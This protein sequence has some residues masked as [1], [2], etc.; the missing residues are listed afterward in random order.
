MTNRTD[1]VSP[2]ALVLTHALEKLR[3]RD[4]L[5]SSRLENS[6]SLEAA[7]LL[8]LAAVRRYAAIQN[9]EIAEAALDVI[10]ECLRESIRGSQSIVADAVLGLGTF[11]EAYNR[12][13][14]D[15]RAVSALRSGLLGMRRN[16]LLASWRSLHEALGLAPLEPPSDRAL[17][18]TVEPAVLRELARQLIRREEYSLGSKSVVM[19]DA[20]ENSPRKMPTSRPGRVL[21]VGGAVMDA[22]FRTKVLPQTGTSSEAYAFE[23]APG[24]KGLNQAVAAARLGLDVA[25]VAAVADDRFGHEIVNHLQDERVDTSL[26][27]QVEDA[28]TPFTGVIEFELGDSLALNWPNQREVRLDVRDLDKYAR[29]FAE[30][31]AVLVTFEIPRE[32]VQHV[33]ALVNN[34]D[35]PRPVVIVT[36]GQPYPDAGISG[37]ALSQIDYLVAHAW[38]LGRYTPPDR[39][40]LD[41][42][43]AARQLLAYGVHTLCVPTVAGCNI[44]SESLG[45][46]SVPTFPSTYRESSVARDAFCAAL[47]AKLIDG[48]REFSEEVALWATTAMAA[49]IADHPLPN[50]MPDR[51]RVEQLLERSRFNVNPRHDQTSDLVSDA[52]GAY[53]QRAEPSFPH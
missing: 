14:I 20:S 29:R 34:L 50:P 3:A 17:R 45:M 5:T 48:G 35:E 28:Q 46:L 25:L 21:V 6:R 22:K 38:E 4:G 31:D 33:V 30:C 40:S 23:L 51:R 53:P 52:V 7:P 49:A 18:G 37:Q 32:T 19:P 15:E 10:K 8:N 1:M 2:N 44:Y 39:Q 12:Y 26:L 42:D 11:S 36:P 9:M 41:V 16:T 24:G 43:A 27:K 13:G 47:A